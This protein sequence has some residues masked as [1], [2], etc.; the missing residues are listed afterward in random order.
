MTSVVSVQVHLQIQLSI[1]TTASDDKIFFRSIS[2]VSD[3]YTRSINMSDRVEAIQWHQVATEICKE[4]SQRIQV[5][6][7]SA[8]T[9]QSRL[10]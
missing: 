2:G 8:N 9:E 1:E 6:G 10:F 5:A 3:R 7:H 4:T